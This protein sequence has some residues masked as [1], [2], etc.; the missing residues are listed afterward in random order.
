M[1]GRVAH[2]RGAFDDAAVYDGFMGRYAVQFAPQFAD[3]AGVGD[4]GRALDV[5]CGTG[6][7]TTELARRLGPQAV[8]GIDPSRPFLA[9]ARARNPEVRFE[10][11]VGEALPFDDGEFDF[12][13]AQL[14]LGHTYDP[15]ATLAEIVRVTAPGGIVALCSWEATAPTPYAPYEAAMVKH[16]PGYERTVRGRR[17]D[18]L[19]RALGLVAVETAELTASVRFERFEDWWTPVSDGVGP[20]SSYIRTLDPASKA[21]LRA[22]CEAELPVA[23]FDLPGIAIAMK[24]VVP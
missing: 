19:L 3:L 12:T 10:R 16:E 7:L 6:A 2:P 18:N 14:A 9:A 8:T 24:G 13:L 20:T 22:G 4:T 23:P 21:R 15:P 17:P 1:A 5:G 11:G